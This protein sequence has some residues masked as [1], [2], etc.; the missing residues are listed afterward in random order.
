MGRLT[1]T[2]LCGHRR[3]VAEA[4]MLRA[5]ASLAFAFRTTTTTTT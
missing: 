2:V 4:P 3:L 5:S 1:P